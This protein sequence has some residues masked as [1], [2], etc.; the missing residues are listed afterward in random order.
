MTRR[1]GR[2]AARES[3]GTSLRSRVLGISSLYSFT[4]ADTTTVDGGTGKVASF[5]DLVRAGSGIRAVDA[6]HALAQAVGANQVV[7]P[8]ADAGLGGK[9]TAAFT[10][11]EIYTS[12]AAASAWRKLHDGTGIE[13]FGVMNVTTVVAGS[14]FFLSTCTGG[15]AAG[16]FWRHVADTPNAAVT[17]GAAQVWN[18]SGT[19]DTTGGTYYALTDNSAQSPKRRMF[20][21][22]VETNTNS[23]ATAPSAGDPELTLSVGGLGGAPGWI[24]NFAALMVFSA[25]L[26][27]ADRALVRAYITAE[28]GVT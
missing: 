22:A 4:H 21:R 26:S 14:R 10:G 24:G 8:T 3:R 15:A 27:D 6:N 16:I 18:M 23:S 7:V 25:V 1:H 12:S 9:R 13:W 28:W 19:A 11:A 5:P 17:N 2:R 20:Q